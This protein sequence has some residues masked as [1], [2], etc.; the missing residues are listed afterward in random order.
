MIFYIKSAQKFSS[1]QIIKIRRNL[2]KYSKI[3]IVKS[4]EEMATWFYNTTRDILGKKAFIANWVPG[5]F[6]F[7]FISNEDTDTILMTK[8]FIR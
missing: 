2:L 6:T 8:K 3:I 1:K 7:L 4:E 5:I